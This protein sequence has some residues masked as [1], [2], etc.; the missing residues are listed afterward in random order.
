MERVLN[1]EQFSTHICPNGEHPQREAGIIYWCD[2]NGHLNSENGLVSPVV[3]ALYDSYWEKAPGCDIYVMAIKPFGLGMG[4]RFTF[5][6]YWPAH[7]ELMKYISSDNKEVSLNAL[8]ECEVAR[9]AEWLR[10]SIVPAAAEVFIENTSDGT[11]YSILVFLPAQNCNQFKEIEDTLCKKVYPQ[12][13]TWLIEDVKSGI[14]LSP[15][16]LNIQF[17]EGAIRTFRRVEAIDCNYASLNKVLRDVAEDAAEANVSTM[18][19]DVKAEYFVKHGLYPAPGTFTISVDSL[20]VREMRMNKYGADI[21]NCAACSQCEYGEC[22]RYGAPVEDSV[23]SKDCCVSDSLYYIRYTQDG[24]DTPDIEEPF[25][26][27]DKKILGDEERKNKLI[28]GLVHEFPGFAQYLDDPEYKKH[29]TIV[30]D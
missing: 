3:K 22:I 17:G 13:C 28:V 30:K 8:H 26:L 15:T 5:N 1:L 27:T 18:L 24:C 9:V 14:R 23:E 7:A 4:M 16:L 6:G 2:E 21:P 20:N 10:D 12:Y 11:A 25:I 19:E 29:I